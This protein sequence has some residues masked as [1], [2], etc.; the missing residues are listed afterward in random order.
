MTQLV[1]RCVWIC[2]LLLGAVVPS[3]FAWADE[4]EALKKGVVRVLAQTD[5]KPREGTGFIVKSQGGIVFVLTAAHVVGD[6]QAP[7]IEFYE[8]KGRTLLARI[9][10]IEAGDEQGLAV[11][12]VE[13]EIPAHTVLPLNH[14]KRIKDGDGVTMVGFPRKLG[15]P[16]AITEGKIVARK[17][18]MILLSGAVEEGN[19]G[20][21]LLKDGDVI[22]VMVSKTANYAYAVPA[23]I[24]K[25]TLESWHVGFAITLRAVPER[26]S[27]EGVGRMI[28]E[29]RF[30]HPSDLS[31]DGLNS[32]LFGDFEHEFEEQTF[33]GHPVVIDRATGLMWQQQGSQILKDELAAGYVEDLNRSRYGGFS[34]WRV[35]TLEEVASLIRP[36]GTNNGLFIDR[37][38]DPVQKT[39]WTSDRVTYNDRFK[40]LDH[41]Y[42]DLNLGGIMA[43]MVYGTL[44]PREAILGEH[45]NTGPHFVRAVRSG[46]E[47]P[48]RSTLDTEGMPG[49]AAE[50]AQDSPSR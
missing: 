24:A 16:W 21:P 19:S 17:G 1:R 29:R 42:V 15:V 2:L 14:E 27:P 18:K 41:W 49:K 12:A 47:R 22:G 43:N 11:L 50:P 37:A 10:G 40:F 30:N 6:A 48:M 35:P 32:S 4:H 5:G 9:V 45:Y 36:T 13:G 8:G 20:G 39:L 33:G 25:Y 7:R 34:D 31:K 38:F 46:M 26:L 44:K 3:G 28:R 23:L